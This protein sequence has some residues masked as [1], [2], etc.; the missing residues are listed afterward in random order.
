MILGKVSTDGL[1]D[2]TFTAKKECSIHFT[3]HYNKFCSGLRYNG[4]NSDILINSTKICNKYKVNNS[5]INSVPLGLGNV[6]K[7]FQLVT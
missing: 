4:A 5:E 1:D 6:S 7:V 3:E 2:T